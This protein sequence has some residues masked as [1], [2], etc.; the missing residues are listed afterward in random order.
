MDAFHMVYSWNNSFYKHVTFNRALGG[1]AEMII[2]QLQFCAGGGTPLC[3]GYFL[4]VAPWLR[5]SG[6]LPA[7]DAVALILVGAIPLSTGLTFW[8]AC[9]G[10]L[11]TTWH[12]R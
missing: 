2:G 10:G 7:G 11:L 12:D 8:P 6:G 4:V 5:L 9:C 1:G 3:T